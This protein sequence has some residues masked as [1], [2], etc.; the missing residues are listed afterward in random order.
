MTRE[1]GV[2]DDALRIL[3]K[4]CGATSVEAFG[5]VTL[6]KVREAMIDELDWSR[7]YINK[8]VNRIRSMIK[9]AAAQEIV[10]AAVAAAVRELVGLKKGRTRARETS[11][12]RPVSDAIVDA[13]LEALPDV[14]A[15]MVRIQR[16]TSARPGEICSIASAEIDRTGDVWIYK[17]VEYKTEHFETNRV[18]AIGPRGQ[19]ILAPYIANR[20]PNSFCFSLAESQSRRRAVANANRKTPLS[21][22]NRAGTNRV[23]AP[24][25]KANDR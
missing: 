4:H 13:T 1:A 20:G 19:Q 23:V 17:P 15:D 9:W 8:Q 22:G 16:L 7:K 6:A 12:I 18:I 25:R 14:V 11:P 5:P 24:Q 2:I 10:D 3:R 21:C